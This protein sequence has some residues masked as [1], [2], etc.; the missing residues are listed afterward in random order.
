MPP[1]VAGSSPLLTAEVIDAIGHVPPESMR[2]IE[3]AIRR[4]RVDSNNSERR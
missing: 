2:K 3:E 1:S 4:D